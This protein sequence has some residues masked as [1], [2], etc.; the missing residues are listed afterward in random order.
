MTFCLIYAC[1]NVLS[2]PPEAL[3]FSTLWTNIEF[4]TINMIWVRFHQYVHIFPIV[5]FRMRLCINI[6][7]CNENLKNDKKLLEEFL[8]HYLGWIQIKKFQSTLLPLALWYGTLWA[9]LFVFYNLLTFRFSWRWKL[10]QSY[11][12]IYESCFHVEPF[13]CKISVNVFKF[14]KANIDTCINHIP[15]MYSVVA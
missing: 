2:H 7:Y 12:T 13:I 14:R 4:E 15:I 11:Q 9:F 8:F 1:N 10:S 5:S 6:F 3:F